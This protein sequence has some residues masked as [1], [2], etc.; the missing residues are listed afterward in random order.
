MKDEHDAK[1]GIRRTVSNRNLESI[2]IPTAP[3]KWQLKN[4]SKVQPYTKAD[5]LSTANDQIT[6]FRATETKEN[7]SNV[8]FLRLLDRRVFMPE[9]CQTAGDARFRMSILQE[10]CAAL[11]TR[12]HDCARFPIYQVPKR[13]ETSPRVACGFRSDFIDLFTPRR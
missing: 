2:P 8:L 5:A 10:L 12:D 11:N 4:N 6:A 13:R 3:I 1:N 9:A 7:S